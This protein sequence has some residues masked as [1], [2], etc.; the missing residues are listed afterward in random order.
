MIA[1]FY[2]FL[3]TFS[4]KTKNEVFLIMKNEIDELIQ[5]NKHFV[6]H[7]AYLPYEATSMPDKNLAILT[8]MDSRLVELLPAALGI[9]NGEVKMIKTAGGTVSSPIGSA[10]RSLLIAIYAFDINNVMVI[11]HDDC[12]MSSPDNSYL[13]EKMKE[14]GISAEKIHTLDTMNFDV[15]KWLSGF[16]NVEDSVRE[17]VSIIKNHPLVSH[18]VTVRGFVMDP[19]TGAIREVLDA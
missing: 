10:M 12:G 13:I 1:I 4:H 9:K 15:E 5:F 3:Y 6:E 16:S 2:F 18:D 7:K 19:T 8:C 14:R 17:S 11:A